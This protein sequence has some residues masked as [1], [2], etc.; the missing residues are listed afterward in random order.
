MEH[1]TATVEK[2][3]RHSP[4]VVTIFFTVH[5]PALF[6]YTAGQYVTVYFENTGTP[7]GKAYSLSSAP[8]EELLS[9]TVKKI[10][11]HSTLLHNLKKGD[12]FE[13]SRAYGYFNPL[14]EK[15][16]VALAAGVGIAPIWSIIK[17]KPLQSATLYYSNKTS[18]DITFH[19]E[20][21]AHDLCHDAFWLHHHITKE[22][23][24]S[25]AMHSGR[26]NLDECVKN[27]EREAMYL[28]CGSVEFVRG[29]FEGL[30]RR[31]VAPEAISTETFFES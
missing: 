26:I 29:M 6:D 31:G 16:F 12:T 3:Q 21:G 7:E 13:I 23:P 30:T 14:T 22:P 5:C 24:V 4:D 1:F 10:G 25:K 27:A 28:I 11:E 2:I 8:S 9:I 15:P 19:D 20:L 17:D 18:Q